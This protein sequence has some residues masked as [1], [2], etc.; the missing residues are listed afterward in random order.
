MKNT[1]NRN[2]ECETMLVFDTC[3]DS[4]RYVPGKKLL[5]LAL[6]LSIRSLLA[7]VSFMVIPPI[8]GYGVRTGLSKRMRCKRLGMQWLLR[9]GVYPAL[10]KLMATIERKKI[11]V[12]FSLY[13]GI[14]P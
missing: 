3:I 2:L 12:L 13:I 8:N 4:I 7:S 6:V 10:Y 9:T 1:A 11:Y 5:S 14:F